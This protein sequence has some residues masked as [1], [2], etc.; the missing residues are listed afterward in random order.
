MG[1][2]ER[3]RRRFLEPASP[4]TWVRL[5]QLGEAP[6][7]RHPAG[8]A[9]KKLPNSHL[10][11][12]FLLSASKSGAGGAIQAGVQLTRSRNVEEHR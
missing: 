3:F 10:F 8:D 5:P 12:N 1:A 11:G 2:A 9:L 4:A 6:Q 7:E